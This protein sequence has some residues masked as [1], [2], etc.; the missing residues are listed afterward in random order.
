MRAATP[1]NTGRLYSGMSRSLGSP[2]QPY[3]NPSSSAAGLGVVTRL[4]T[5]VTNMQ[6][7]S[8]QSAR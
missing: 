6:I 2:V 3:T 5:T 4:T 1:Q 8:D 7:S